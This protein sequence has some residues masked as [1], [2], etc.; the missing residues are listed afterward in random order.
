MGTSQR[1]PAKGDYYSMLAFA[2][3]GLGAFTSFVFISNIHGEAWRLAVTFLLGTIYILIGTFS[4][5]F[6]DENTRRQSAVFALQV[7]LVLIIV[8]VSPIRGFFGIIALPLASQAVFI[9]PRL[10]A[11]AC[12][13]GIYLA[14]TG[15][16]WMLYGFDVYREV[17][18]SYSPAYLFTMVFSY[19][20]QNALLA[21][22]HAMALSNQLEAANAQLR[23][24]AA[25][26]EELATTRERNRLAREIHDG[27]GHYLTVINIQLEAAR[28]ICTKDPAKAALAVEKAAR[29]SREALD[30]VRRS[31]GTLRTDNQ[32]PPLAE[33]IRNLTTDA[34]LP[35]ELTIAGEPRRLPTAAEH[36]LYRA[37]QEGLTNVRK[38][39]RASRA[40]LALDFSHDAH[41]RLSV[42]DDGQGAASTPSSDGFGLQG[43][44]ERIGLLGGQV[45]AGPRPAGGFTLTVE[46]P[47]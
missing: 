26:A 18:V 36:A 15:V 3:T 2:G 13:I 27:V 8:Y 9:F 28:S 10:V 38:H 6:D 19:V 29:L 11:L 47:V 34:G 25:Q 45:T 24:Q 23:A 5:R 20:T 16:F 42:E 30:D 44:R 12:G 22:E 41:I 33:A 39:A 21:R 17:L 43:M 4:Y 1:A 40:A 37:A 46:V 35:V 32:L 31:V 14:A 7:T